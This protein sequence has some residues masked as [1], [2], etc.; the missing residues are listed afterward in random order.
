[1]SGFFVQN[2]WLIPFFPL[3]GAA[4]AAFGARRL[5]STAHIPVVAGIALAFL[6]SLG[7]LFSSGPETTTVVSRLAGHQRA[8]TSPS[9]SGSTG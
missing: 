3:L 5:R 9:N 6:V 7:A 2:V 4:V 1:M 8:A